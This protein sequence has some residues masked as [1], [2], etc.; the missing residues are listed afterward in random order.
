MHFAGSHILEPGSLE[1]VCLPCSPLLLSLRNWKVM[2]NLKPIFHI[3]KLRPWD[4]PGGL[5][6]KTPNAGGKGSIPN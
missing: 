3:R 1:M 6:V 5:M 2:K 4:F